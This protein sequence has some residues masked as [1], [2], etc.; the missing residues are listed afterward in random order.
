LTEKSVILKEHILRQ[1]A[2]WSIRSQMPQ[3]YLHYFGNESS[4]N[5]LQAYGIITKEKQDI[6][7]LRPK[8]CPNCN[9]SNIPNSKFCSKCRMV[10]NYDSYNEAIENAQQKD[11]EIKTI[12]EQIQ[13]LILAVN[14]MKD[15]NQI[16][17]FTH[18]LFNAG[19]FQVSKSTTEK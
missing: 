5:I 17:D 10:L 13:A 18:Q 2:G 1:Y 4:Q 7:K 19:I 3:K 11:D 9:E 6:D 12:K 15:Q 14:S 8:Q 16:N